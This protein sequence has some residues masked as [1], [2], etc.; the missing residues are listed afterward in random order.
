MKHEVI[1]VNVN[2]I[3]VN[4]R[5]RK[6]MGDLE[7][8]A[9]SIETVGLLQPIIIQWENRLGWEPQE[10]ILI[11][12][13]RRL[14]AFK[15][16]RERHG[17]TE[18]SYIPA[19][20]A[21]NLDDAYHLLLAERD[22]NTCRKDFV[23][24]E[25]IALGLA[26]EPMEKEAAKERR[27]AGVNQYSAPSGKLPEPP[28]GDTRD[29]VGASVGMSGKT[30]EKGKSVV[31]AA[32]TLAMPE[33]IE[34]MDN[35]SVESAYREMIKV[36]AK[37]PGPIPD[38]KYR[39]IYADPPWEYGNTMPKEFV[40]QRDH[41]PTM[42]LKEICELPIKNLAQENAVLFLW[43]TSPMLEETFEVVAAWGFKYK[44]SFIWDKVKHVM[45]HYN[46]VR[47][48]ILLI[49]VRGSCQPDNIKLFDSVYSEE[50]TEHSRKPEYFRN[51]IDT[52]YPTGKRIELFARSQHDN[53]DNWGNEI[54]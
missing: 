33:L 44:S 3:R 23:P 29:K 8:L 32:E 54:P 46:S 31:Y 52:I 18:Y 17:G 53:W 38:G 25:A 42:K 4:G 20:I 48:E 47:H 12:G 26:L 14:E 5:H 6:D 34:I 10:P 39:V 36:T 43:T 50:R 49:C 22:E 19:C 37:E 11:G 15:L 45:G 16:L 24:S 28:K 41:Y 7:S 35:K 2:Q 1:S 9:N 40:E 51:I 13:K 27:E 21:K 30:Y